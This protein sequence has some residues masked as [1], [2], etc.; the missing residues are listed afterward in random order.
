MTGSA[1]TAWPGPDY[2]DL[3]YFIDTPTQR[4]GYDYNLAH[5][6]QLP[7][8]AGYLRPPAAPAADGMT[9]DSG[10]AWGSHVGRAIDPV[11]SWLRN[12]SK[13]P[14]GTEYS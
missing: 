10:P 8:P 5:P 14:F 6:A 13:Y 3:I 11:E 12:C 2:P 4:D 1:C 7:K 9:S